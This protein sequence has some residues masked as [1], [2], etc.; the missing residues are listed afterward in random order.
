MRRARLAVAMGSAALALMGVAA[1]GFGVD[2]DGIFGGVPG[3]G[4]TSAEGS[5]DGG[6]DAPAEASI[7]SLPVAQLGMGGNYGCGRRT[8]GTVMCW[9]ATEVG[10]ELGD[11]LQV[12]SSTPVLAT[13]VADAVDISVGQHHV[14]V[15]RRGGTVSCWGYNELRQLG[16][17]TTNNSPTAKDVV[18]LTD[19]THVAVGYAHSCALKKD[20]TVQCWGD[21]KSG[22]LGDGS[23]VPRSQ[24]APVMG[25]ADVTQIASAEGTTCAL[26]KSGEVSCW[27]KNDVG[28]A[29]QGTMGQPPPASVPVP[30]KVAGLAGVTMIAAGSQADHFCALVGTEVRCWGAGGNG[31]LGNAKSQDGPVPVTALGINDAAGVAT[32]GRHTCAWRKNGSVTCWGRNDWRQLGLGDSATSDDVSSPVPVN[33]LTDVKMVAGGR[34]HTCALSTDGG[35]ISC[36]GTNVSGALG[37]GTK[38]TSALPLKV[39]LP[40]L[41]GFA[42]GDSHACAFD[43]A[44]AFT[45]WGDNSLRQLGFDT[46]L[47]TGTPTAVT[48]ITGVTHAAA[49]DVH[50]C[51][52]V[53]G[54]EIKC[55]GH[56]QYG[57]LGNGATRYVQLPPV[58]F[59]AGSATDVGAGFYFTCALL[60]TT[61]VTCV[62]RNDEVRLGAPG[63]S[64]S[65]PSIVANISPFDAGGS[66]AGPPPAGVTKLSVGRSHSCVLRAGGVVTC[67]GSNGGGECGQ[68]PGGATTPVDVSL[69]NAATEVASG[70]GHTCVLLTD[71]TVR[72]FGFNNYGQTTG[73][74]QQGPML[75]TPDLGGIKAKTIIAGDNHSCAVLMDGTV[76]CWGR[77]K[78][79]QLGNGLRSDATSP[80][81]VTNLATVKSLAARDSRT[82][83]VL[84]DG[85]GYCWGNNADGELGDGTIM[86]TGSPAAVVGY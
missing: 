17:G 61:D 12:A 37:R 85:S 35:H 53:G 11:G 3:E 21:N 1:C 27:G 9:G 13:G 82:C 50:T 76:R 56:N 63:S 51:A 26:L 49:G 60:G 10:G 23:V 24:P 78:S 70:D 69:P 19:V 25:L 39:A 77:G 81:V 5:L 75:Q 79:G 20:A 6:T 40:T 62:G 31:Q 36:W 41:A 42:M 68:P 58:T 29:G 43:G 73:G 14:C 67:W 57:E 47:A 72:C 52:L 64:T 7:P 38:I 86:T 15:A 8:D 80:V 44:G 32:G 65:T 45:C 2:L 28:Q 48:G 16:D 46:V 74:A 83:A 22:Q 18:A 55:W 30:A 59:T 33:G 54:G 66:E 34:S 4:G 84:E 71:G